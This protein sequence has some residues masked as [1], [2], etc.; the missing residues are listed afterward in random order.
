M[1]ICLIGGSIRSKARLETLGEGCNTE[2]ALAEVKKGIEQ[3]GGEIDYIRLNNYFKKNGTRK[4]GKELFKKIKEADGIVIASPVYFGTATS[5]VDEFLSICRERKI[6]L[7]PKVVGFVAVGAKRNGGE[8]TT[9]VS[10]SW[11]VMELGAIVVNDGAPIS[12]FGGVGVAGTLRQMRYDRE[13]LE[14]CQNL[15]KRVAETTMI[16]QKGR[17]KTQSEIKI[18]QM[19]AKPIPKRF[20]SYKTIELYQMNFHRCWGCETC[21][22]PKKKDMDFKCRNEKDDIHKIHQLLVNSEGIIPIGWNMKFIERTRYL[23]RDN[24]QLTYSVVYIPSWEYIPIFIKENSI[25]CRKHFKDYVSLIKSGRAKLSL[26]KQIYEP[27]GYT[28]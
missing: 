15:G 1:K 26:T 24:F 23:R 7:Y 3:K 22:D 10:L 11:R 20:N 18:W 14:V 8:E 6:S 21:P 19:S 2:I 12:Q 17:K 9:I 27:R 4:D 13:G 16:I 28:I 25:L 5:L